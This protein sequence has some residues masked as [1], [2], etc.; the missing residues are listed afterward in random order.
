MASTRNKNTKGNYCLEQR[1]YEESRQYTTYKYSSHGEAYTTSLPG[2]GLLPAQIPWNQLSN[3]APDI[4]SY[5][6]G[7]SSTNLVEPT[8]IIK[9]ELK[10][11]QSAN[12]YEKGPILMPEHLVIEKGQRPMRF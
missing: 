2:N 1:S 7:I 11:L 3:N 10:N 5:L 12:I 9:P 4:E 8:P 6:Y